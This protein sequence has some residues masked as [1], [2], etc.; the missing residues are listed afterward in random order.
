MTIKRLSAFSVALGS[1]VFMGL[2]AF[3]VS[4]AETQ[5][6]P[7]AQTVR[8][9]MTGIHA[10][11]LG[12]TKD[13]FVEAMKGGSSIRGLAKEQ[14]LTF[15]QYET[16]LSHARVSAVQKMEKDGLI[17][18]AQADRWTSHLTRRLDLRL[19]RANWYKQM[20]LQNK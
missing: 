9:G 16:N 19:A 4:A 5:P 6:L 17:T 11:A 20:T 10:Q 7:L 1:A 18:S 12:M 2:Q 8:N 13:A 15:N 14:G 3:P